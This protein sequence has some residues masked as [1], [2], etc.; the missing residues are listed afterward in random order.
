MSLIKFLLMTLLCC[1]LTG[2]AG[3]QTS[4]GQL[5]KADSGHSGHSHEE[6]KA[7]RR[8]DPLAKLVIPDIEVLNQDGKKVRFYTDLVKGKKV[9]INFVYTSCE[10]TCPMAGRN[11]D[12]LQ[13]SIGKEL[14]KEVFLISVSTDPSVDTPQILKKW[15]EKYNRQDGWTLVTGDE[16]IISRLLTVLIGGSPR[17]GLHA[18]LVILFDG[19]SE[20]WDATTSLAEPKVLLDS[21]SKLGKGAAKRNLN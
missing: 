8:N 19:V 14:G 13:K 6:S 11:F 5:E 4:E 7:A 17:R 1:C 18:P 2:I 9:L 16:S 10:L 12:K 15:G 3:A 20:V 21:L